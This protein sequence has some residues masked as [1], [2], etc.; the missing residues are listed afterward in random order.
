MRVQSALIPGIFAGILC[1]VVLT[2][3]IAIPQTVLASTG[4]STPTPAEAAPIAQ[5]DP[6]AQETVVQEAALKEQSQSAPT[7]SAHESCSLGAR[8]NDSIRQWCSLIEKYASESGLEPN[9]VGAVMVQESGGNP[10]AVSHSGA[11]GLLQVMPR[12]GIAASFMCVNGPCFAS[13]PSSEELKDPEFNIRYGTRMLAGLINK[14]GSVRDGLMA[15]GPGEVG[16]Y[17]ADKVLAI[18]ES[19]R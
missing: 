18:Y 13:R 3:L 4:D 10:Q 1:V 7:G 14:R 11:V 6:A 15:Y 16:Y 8:F 19:Y 17:Y 12:D 9:L 5:E 2:N